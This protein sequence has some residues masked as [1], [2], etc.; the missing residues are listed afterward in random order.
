[1]ETIIS[2]FL[3]PLIYWIAQRIKER[4]G[5]SGLPALWMVYGLSL[6]ASFLALLLSGS[7]AA[8]PLT[9]PPAFAQALLQNAALAFATATAIYRYVQE[10]NSAETP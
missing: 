3:G 4:T 5:L 9:D 8:L 6:L 2:L 1:M 10:R 7:L